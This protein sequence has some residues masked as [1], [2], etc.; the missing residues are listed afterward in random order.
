MCYIRC[1]GLTQ[2]DI[3]LARYI[4]PREIILVRFQSLVEFHIPVATNI[5]REDPD[6]IAIY[7]DR[8]VDRIKSPF[9]QRDP[10]PLQLHIFP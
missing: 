3:L 4:K 7:S 2:A 8:H 6:G 9:Q 1:L 10:F 5:I